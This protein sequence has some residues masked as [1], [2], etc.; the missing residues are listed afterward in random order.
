MTGVDGDHDV[1]FAARGSRQL[2][3]WQGRG[4]RRGGRRRGSDGWWLGRGARGCRLI[5]G[6]DHQAMTVLFIGRLTEALRR[7]RRMHIDYPTQCVG[8]VRAAIDSSS[9]WEI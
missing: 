1:A 6:V 4:N 7:Y 2:H 9:M 5:E 3:R 8:P